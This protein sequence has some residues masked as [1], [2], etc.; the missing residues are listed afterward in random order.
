LFYFSYY[1]TCFAFTFVLSFKTN[2]DG[3]SNSK[4]KLGNSG[5]EVLA[6]GLGC[7]GMSFGDYYTRNGLDLKTRELLTFSILLSLGGCEPQL[8][9]HVQGNL[10]VGND[11]QV[12]LITVTQ[13][14]PY[15]GY[16]RTLNGIRC[17]N[18]VIPE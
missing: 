9:G 4:R 18:E 10:N 2:D 11:K 15:I 12:L 8:K 1:L 6:I 16:P 14:L 5:L 13:L 17:I 3:T 7:M